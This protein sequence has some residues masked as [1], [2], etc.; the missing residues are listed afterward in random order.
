MKIS[1]V[2]IRPIKGD[3]ITN[4]EKHRNFILRAVDWHADGV[5]FPELSLTG[6]EPE[7]ANE[8]A[9]TKEDH[10]LEL[11]QQLSDQKNITIGIG[12]PTKTQ[13]GVRISMLIFQPWKERQIYSKQQL[14]TDEFPFFEKGIAQLIVTIDQK[15]IAPAI[16]FESLQASHSEKANILGADIYLASVAKSQAG[17]NKA[18]THFAEVAKKY[19]MPVL[20][21]NC[22]GN[23]DN[24]LSKGQSAVWTKDGKL[25]G[26]LDDASEGLLIFDT[27]TEEVWLEIIN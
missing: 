11:F 1:I 21:S 17:V 18:M 23:C 9:I 7:L 10:R 20:M 13:T 6:Y 2:Q 25:A 14:H 5:F 16:C 3:I 22:V 26:Q 8:L 19:G 4:I 15:K 12:V 24:F 27:E